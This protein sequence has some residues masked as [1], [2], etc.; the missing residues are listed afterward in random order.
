DVDDD[1]AVRRLHAVEFVVLAGVVSG[2]DGDIAGPVPGDPVIEADGGSELEAEGAASI[3]GGIGRAAATDIEQA[4]IGE[5]HG[6]MRAVDQRIDAWGPGDAA[7]GRT[8]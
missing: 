1:A 3:A 5:L 4:A 7:I 8:D 2:H 6:A